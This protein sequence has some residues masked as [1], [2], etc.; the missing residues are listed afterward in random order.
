MTRLFKTIVYLSLGVV[1]L[2]CNNSEKN[3]TKSTVDKP[4]EQ[5]Y[6]YS[7]DTTGI[8]VLWTAYKFTDKVGVPGT[9]DRIS[10][11]N[12]EASGSIENLLNKAQ[13]SIQTASVNSNNAIRDPKINTFF[14]K[15]FNTPEIKGTILDAKEG[16]GMVKLYMNRTT[17][18]TPFTYSIE[19]DTIK[20][21][22]HLDLGY[23]N[24]EEG[25]TSLNTECYDLHKGADGISKLWPDVDVVIKLPVR[26][27]PVM[28]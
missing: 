2:S 4:S 22:A 3:K 28:E 25:I 21:I 17:H 6:S 5:L 23:W 9:F 15:P 14:F 20:V 19:N 10:F 1:V 11:N 12:T 26:K 24:G 8:S 18:E 27:T 16:E 13:L 7:V